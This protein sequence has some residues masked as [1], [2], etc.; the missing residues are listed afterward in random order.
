MI[1]ST[2]TRSLH[3]VQED[4]VR[5]KAMLEVLQER[6]NELMKPYADMLNDPNF[7]SNGMIDRYVDIEMDIEEQLGLKSAE[8]HFEEAQV[9]L[10]G[11]ARREI[12]KR[13]DAKR[14][15]FTEV[16]ALFERRLLPSQLRKLTD[17][18]MRYNPEAL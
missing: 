7:D 13:I 16:S 4:Y 18:C 9:N 14:E 10:F 2:K 3:P 17:I 11:W 6:R 1:D 15:G 8:R 5:A 12:E